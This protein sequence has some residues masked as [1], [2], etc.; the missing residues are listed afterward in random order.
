MHVIDPDIGSKTVPEQSRKEKKKRRT[1]TGKWIE[2]KYADSS[3]PKR[4]KFWLAF[5][6]DGGVLEGKLECFN[7]Y[8]VP[9]GHPEGHR[10]SASTLRSITARALSHEHNRHL[11]PRQVHCF[12]SS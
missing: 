8:M 2:V 11:P 3:A 6:D 7:R 10:Q 4:N 1:R 9:F 12:H 5:V